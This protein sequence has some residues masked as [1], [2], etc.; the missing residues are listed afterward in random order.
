VI[1][2]C[3]QTLISCSQF[4][5]LKLGC[6]RP[7]VGSAH[8]G[9]LLNCGTGLHTT[10]TPDETHTV[11]GVIVRHRSTVDCPDVDVRNVVDRAIV[12]YFI[13][14]PISTVISVAAI[15]V[16]VVDSTIVTDARGPVAVVE[17]ISAAVPTPVGRCPEIANAWRSDPGAGHPVEVVGVVVPRPEARRPHIAVAGNGGLVVDGKQRRGVADADDNR[18]LSLRGTRRHGCSD[19]QSEQ[20][21]SH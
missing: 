1:D 4:T 8:D 20:Q 2:A 16:T 14:S 6:G 3:P 9:Q 19:A 18:D 17:G 15:A 21:R 10:R 5:V 7:H 11:A 12:V 13:V